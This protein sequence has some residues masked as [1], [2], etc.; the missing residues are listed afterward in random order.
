MRAT[1]RVV[2]VAL[3]F[4]MLSVPR[5]AHAVAGIYV[6]VDVTVG[7]SQTL[8]AT[9]AFPLPNP[10]TA[11]FTWNLTS[12]PPGLAYETMGLYDDQAHQPIC[13]E[14][15]VAGTTT[16]PCHC[17]PREPRALAASGTET[18]VFDQAFF[19]CHT[20]FQGLKI[21]AATP[22]GSYHV[23]GTLRLNFALQA[24][25]H[26]T[27]SSPAAG[28]V[29]AEG[30]P[31]QVVWQALGQMASSVRIELIPDVE[32]QAKRVLIPSTPNDGSQACTIPTPFPGTVKIRVVTIDNKVSGESGSFTIGMPAPPPR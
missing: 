11:T 5:A 28:A 32:P 23:R 7:P 25:A 27:V 17:Y 3:I 8:V 22:T 9:M 6:N 30:K 12:E 21:R 10:T 31:F 13:T 29:V 20:H 14:D 2:L 16:P 24:P 26:I 19:G 1:T 18:W 4:V 15:L